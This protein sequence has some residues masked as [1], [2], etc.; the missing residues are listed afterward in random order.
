MSGEAYELPETRPEPLEPTLASIDEV[1]AKSNE[2]LFIMGGQS[3]AV[4]AIYGQDPQLERMSSSSSSASIPECHAA[5]AGGHVEMTTALENLA[6]HK[7]KRA[8]KQV[9]YHVSVPMDK[10]PLGNDGYRE[11]PS[12]TDTTSCFDSDGTYIR[13]EAQSSD[14]GAALLS[15]S[16]RR[17]RDRKGGRGGGR[18]GPGMA[19]GLKK[20][21]HII[22]SH[23]DFFRCHD[24]KY[25]L[26]ARQACFWSSILSIL[27]CIGTAAVLIGLMPRSCDPETEWWQGGTILDVEPS[28]TS[29]TAYLN[30]TD[31]INNVPRYKI[32][33]I[34]AL[35]IRSLY[36]RQENMSVSNVT[37]WFGCKD[38]AV[39]DRLEMVQL[40]S[41]ADIL[42]QNGMQLVVEIPV[43]EVVARDGMM[44]LH[45]IQ[46]VTLAIKDWAERGVDGISL[47]GLEQFARDPYFSVTAANWKVNFNKYGTSPYQKILSASHLLPQKLEEVHLEAAGSSAAPEDD[48]FSRAVHTS[49]YDGIASFE[50]LDATL[51]LG[52]A[53][54]GSEEADLDGLVA[55]IA[56]WDHAPTQP[57][58]SW[59]LSASEAGLS[60]NEAELALN[61]L[62]PGTVSLKRDGL[63]LSSNY[64]RSILAK[65][66]AIRR[67]SVPIYMNGNYKTCHAHCD[68]EVEKVDNYNVHT[69]SNSS[70][71][72]LERNFNRRNRYMVIANLGEVEAELEV[73]ASLYSTGDVILD[74]SNID[75]EPESIKFKETQL[76]AKQA[77]VIKFPK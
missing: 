17:G 71:L 51:S 57:W 53:S 16:K 44:T 50:L 18:G 19:R 62:L 65:L 56:R 27:A 29:D 7:A 26:V 32:L 41:L 63:D 39:E 14:S 24:N 77:L 55:N 48:S 4:N 11:L 34:Q 46:N 23:E 64:T 12:D 38:K 28:W 25:W 22:R 1:S 67:A 54:L 47:L 21:R 73:V 31:L 60:L 58:I 10:S 6:I 43:M 35:K 36:I 52:E 15:H 40:P 5:G 9:S 61:M 20:A 45:L 72:M 13:S 74:T 49:G 66:S 3:V 8:K 42:H 59:S 76:A 2:E 30:L 33:G 69:S 37:S 68:G 70:L 75:R